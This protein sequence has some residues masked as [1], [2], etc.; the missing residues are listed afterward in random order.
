MSAHG[1]HPR[2][3][4]AVIAA[5]AVAVATIRC[6]FDARGASRVERSFEQRESTEDEE[7]RAQGEEFACARSERALDDPASN[8]RPQRLCELSDC[9]V[10]AVTVCDGCDASV[11]GREARQCGLLDCKKG[12]DLAASRRNDTD[13]ALPDGAHGTA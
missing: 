9:L 1:E 7:G 10:A 2:A 4:C 6:R 13:D 11:F 8:E 5:A 12:T 3:A